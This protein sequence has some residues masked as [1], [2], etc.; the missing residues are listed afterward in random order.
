MQV[1]LAALAVAISVALLGWMGL[2]DP[3]RIR[4]H[5]RDLPLHRPFSALQRRWLA[6]GAALPGLL[7]LLGGWWSSAIMWSGATVTLAWL[8]VAWLARPRR[9]SAA[10]AEEAEAVDELDEVEE[11]EA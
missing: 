5:H 9:I 4:A 6:L 10:L 1:V 11:T 2:R 3:R 7:L 8:W